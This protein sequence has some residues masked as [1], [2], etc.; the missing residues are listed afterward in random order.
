MRVWSE[1]V[2]FHELLKN[3]SEIREKLSEAELAEC[4]DIRHH[5]RH[6]ERVYERL[7]I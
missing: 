7:G 4:F 1:R 3:D 5:M 2:D 6:L